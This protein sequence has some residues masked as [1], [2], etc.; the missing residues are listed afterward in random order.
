MNDNHAIQVQEIV[1]GESV[2]CPFC[3]F[4]ILPGDEDEG[5]EFDPD[6]CVCEHTLFVATDCGFE[7]RSSL[8]NH[9]MGLPDD[10]D[11]EPDL[12]VD[13]DDNSMNYDAFT[14]KVRIPESVKIASYTPAPGCLGAYFGF[15]PSQ[16][17]C[18]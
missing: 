9:H 10:Q 18:C 14:S 13:D 16:A 2:V 12:P 15:A 7:Y 17:A 5:F 8:F 11:S 1:S 4:Q 3:S 6:T